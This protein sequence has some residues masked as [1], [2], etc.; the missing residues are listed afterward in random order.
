VEGGVYILQQYVY[1]VSTCNSY[2]TC[3]S[4]FTIKRHKSANTMRA[5]GVFMV[6]ILNNVF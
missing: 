6:K 1:P 4:V 5:H 2:N 3:V